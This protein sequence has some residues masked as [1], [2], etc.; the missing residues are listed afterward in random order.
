MGYYTTFNLTVRHEKEA[1]IIADLRAT[2]ED[3][4]YALDESGAAKDEC[5]WYDCEADIIEFS[6]KYPDALFEMSGEG[7]DAGGDFWKLYAKNGKSFMAEGEIIY[8]EFNLEK[9]K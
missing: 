4:E 7:S 5:K 8:P 1:E 2:N 3:A 9:L 6:K